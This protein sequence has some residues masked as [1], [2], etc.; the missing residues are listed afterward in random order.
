MALTAFVRTVDRGS[1]A[2]AARELG[3]TPA[4]VG[5]HLRALEDR[6]GAR[7]LNRT[8]ATQSLTEAGTA[9]FARATAVL[10]ALDAAEHASAD[11]GAVPRGLLR[12][13]GPMV[14]GV[15]FLAE[16][17]AAFCQAHPAVNVDLTLNDR[18]V[19]LVEEGFDVAVRIGRLAESSLVARR[20]ASCRL[21]ACASPEYLRRHGGAP[22]TPADL[23]RH[24]CLIYSYA[25]AG[26]SAWTFV[27]PG[28]DGQ[29]AEEYV[30]LSGTLAANNGE[31]LL[32]A[33]LAGLGVIIEPTFIVCEALRTGRLVTLLPGYRLPELPIHAV[34]P[35]SRH[36]APKVRGLVDFLLH[37]FRDPPPWE[38]ASAA[39]ESR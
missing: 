36:L 18:V 22:D 27:K 34:F 28:R 19:D 11:P 4:M 37:W 10:E 6:L 1:Q 20:L 16:A 2:A 25:S 15:R 24:N 8:T 38:R 32:E 9:F 7:L 5:R 30:R 14:F 12:V 39:A 17:V 23:R 29:N 3:I 35:S 26:G 33:A 31:A 21:V 13:N